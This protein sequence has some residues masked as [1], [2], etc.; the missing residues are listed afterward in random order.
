[1]RKKAKSEKEKVTEEYFLTRIPVLGYFFRK[2]KENREA[3]ETALKTGKKTKGKTA[4]KSFLWIFK[5]K[6]NKTFE[7]LKLKKKK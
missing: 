4:K 5:I 7:T 3:I 2:I 1:M 6:T